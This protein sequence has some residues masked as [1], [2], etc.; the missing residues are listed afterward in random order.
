ML[1]VGGLVGPFFEAMSVVVI[2]C[3]L[4][5]LVESKLILPAHLAHAKIKPVDEEDLFNPQR[6]IKK[7]EVIPRFFQKLQRRT[8]RGLHGLIHNHYAPM[9]KK[10]L[11][12]RGLTFSIFAGVLILTFGLTNSA[13]VRVVLFPDVPS[14]FVAV[15]MEMQN[16]TAPAAR[17]AAIDRIE[18]A[19]LAINA[20]FVA[21]NPDLQEPV[22]HL[23]AFTNGDSGAQM[24]AELVK[25]EER[26]LSSEAVIELWRERVGEIPGMKDLS[27]RVATILAAVRH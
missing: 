7:R 19:I 27:F 15:E 21:E 20:E 3:L 24:F 9:L 17:D 23:I 26:P 2:L 5:S 10:S 14:D 13:L 12:N 25:G 6:T 11:N 16:G 1:F 18:A 22:E 4:F 8:Q